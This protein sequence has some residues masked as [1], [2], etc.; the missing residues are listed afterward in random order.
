MTPEQIIFALRK[1]RRIEPTVEEMVEAL[2]RLEQELPR[3]R[4]L[5]LVRETA[6]LT[7]FLGRVARA[8]G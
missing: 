8:R 1:G 6:D 2:P 3:W 7:G 4:S 5:G